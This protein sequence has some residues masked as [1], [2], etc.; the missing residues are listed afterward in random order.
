MA[1]DRHFENRHISVKNRP[2]L[3]Q[4][5][6][7]TTAVTWPKIETFKI[8]TFKIQHGGQPSSSKAFLDITQQA[9]I[10]FQKFLQYAAA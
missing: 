8:K 10:R 7:Y 6:T 3:M 4:F 2:I 5:G 1:E 9:I